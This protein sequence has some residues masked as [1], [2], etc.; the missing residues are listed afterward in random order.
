MPRARLPALVV[1]A[2]LIGGPAGVA[3]R[4][5]PPAGQRSWSIR[6]RAGVYSASVSWR[7]PAGLNAIGG[8]V[9]R[10]TP[11]SASTF[12]PAGARRAVVNALEPGV[13]YRFRVSAA[14]R[15]SSPSAP[16]RPL[17]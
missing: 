6:V 17:S 15:S 3:S 16:V 2:A 14:G 4:A 11:G 12:A 1:G 7:A 5:Q 9:I 13:A 8:Y 10:A